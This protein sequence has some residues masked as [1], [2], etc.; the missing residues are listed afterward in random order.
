MSWLWIVGFVLLAGCGGSG[1][2]MRQ[3][4]IGTRSDVLAVSTVKT[5]I[6]PGFADLRIAFSVKTHRSGLH[7]LESG[8]RGSAGYVLV[9]NIDGH[10]ITL[11]GVM[12]EEDT[13]DEQLRTPETGFGMRYRFEKVLRLRAGVHRVFIAVPEDKVVAEKEI[14]LEGGTR[15]DLLLD[16]VYGTGVK[17]TYGIGKLL[18][19]KRGPNFTSHLSSIRMSMNGK[20]L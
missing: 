9:V 18:F 13:V 1:E 4:S 12:S 11:S 6:P 20:P 3:Q 8:T 7:A 5:A 14:R 2:L 15:R 19:G 16:P 10:A 17:P